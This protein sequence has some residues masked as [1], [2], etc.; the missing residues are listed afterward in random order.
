MEQ[1]NTELVIGALDSL[2]LALADHN[3][4]WTEG[5]RAIYEKAIEVLQLPPKT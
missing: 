2:G 5:E 4:Q 1:E 3:H